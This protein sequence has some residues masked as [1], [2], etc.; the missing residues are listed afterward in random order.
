[1]KILFDTHTHTLASAHAYST[2][3]ENAT[4]A[5]SVGME[6]IAI[7]DHCVGMSDAPHIWHFQNLRNIPRTLNGVKI[8]YGVELNLLNS[9]GELDMDDSLMK[10]LDVVNVSIHG[11]CYDTLGRTDHTKAYEK[12]ILNPYTDIIAHSGSVAFPYD[13]EKIIK[14]AKKHH[15]LIEI[16]NHTFFVRKSS[17]EN[18]KKIAKL[19]MDNEVGI[20]VSSDAHIHEDIGNYDR[21]LKMLKEISFP[22][23]LI[24]NR[25]LQSYE[26]YVKPRKEILKW[27]LDS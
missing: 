8:L 5:A 1:M 2:V 13:Y 25:D 21:A 27:S 12:A 14:L 18:C 3:T 15:K 4:Y 9:D 17:A 23:K 24:I 11:P 16:N 20:V 7:T 26:N 19:C 22:E 6:A 10:K